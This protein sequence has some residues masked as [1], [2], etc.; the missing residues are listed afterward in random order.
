LPAKEDRTKAFEI[1][2]SIARSDS[3]LDVHEATLLNK[4]ETI[5]FPNR[6]KSIPV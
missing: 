1:A 3:K 4:V 6:K 2:T 5:L